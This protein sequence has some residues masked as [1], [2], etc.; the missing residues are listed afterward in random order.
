MCYLV[1]KKKPRF[2]DGARN[3]KGSFRVL[4]FCEFFT[5]TDSYPNLPPNHHRNVSRQSFKTSIFPRLR[6]RSQSVIWLAVSCESATGLSL[7]STA[8][9]SL[10]RVRSFVFYNQQIARVASHFS[11]S[12]FPP[13][14]PFLSIRLIF[15]LAL[16]S[17]PSVVRCSTGRSIQTH[18]LLTR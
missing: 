13:L 1:A 5:E 14:G 11:F 6:Y 10:A 15:S 8:V 4:P 2:Q 9:Y 16:V 17:R 18:I 3:L 7:V 12:L